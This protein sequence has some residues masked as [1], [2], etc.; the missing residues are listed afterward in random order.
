VQVN[1]T[2]FSIMTFPFLFA[3][4]FGDVG[5]GLL[6]LAFALFLVINEKKFLKQQLNEIFAMA[7]GGRWVL[8]RPPWPS[9][10]QRMHASLVLYCLPCLAC[11][12]LL[13]ATSRHAP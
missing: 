11:P 13:P 7:F 1:P 2:V 8:H 6:M 4:M 12:L 10:C 5:H 3:V 9:S